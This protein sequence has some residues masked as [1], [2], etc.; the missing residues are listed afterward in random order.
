VARAGRRP[1]VSTAADQVL[2]AARQLFAERGF[3]ATTIRAVAA[4]AQVNPALVHHY[5]GDKEQLFQAAMDL[6]VPPAVLI[7]QITAGPR[8]EIAERLVRTFLRIWRD[9]VSGQRMLGIVRA[10]ATTEQGAIMLR[11]FA[12]DVMLARLPAALGVPKER[13]AAAAA[14]LVGVAFA[15]LIA[16]VEPLASMT[17]DEL[18]TL[19]VPAIRT[20][21]G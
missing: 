6:P 7:S 4:A 16:R 1:G 18:V 9:P 11:R 2:S 5:F 21:L 12:Q 20:Y 17:D 15:M 13:V 14:H 8:A 10:A 3:Q 19:L